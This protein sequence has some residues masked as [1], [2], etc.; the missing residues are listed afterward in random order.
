MP[1]PLTI[2]FRTEEERQAFKMPEPA[3]LPVV[4]NKKKVK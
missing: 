1:F 2:Y 3:P 4:E